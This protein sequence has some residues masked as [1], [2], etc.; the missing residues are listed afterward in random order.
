MGTPPFCFRKA[1]ACTDQ[2]VSGRGRRAEGKGHRDEGRGQRAKSFLIRC[3]VP[4]P[5]LP[6]SCLITANP[7]LSGY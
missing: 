3:F 1:Q 5:K 4:S 2:S 6:E 7:S